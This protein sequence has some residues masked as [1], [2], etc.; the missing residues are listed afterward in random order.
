MSKDGKVHI[1]GQFALQPDCSIPLKSAVSIRYEKHDPT[2]LDVEILFLGDEMERAEAYRATRAIDINLMKLHAINKGEDSI[3]LLGLTGWRSSL[4]SM[5]LEVEAIEVGID[6]EPANRPLDVDFTVALQPS[7]ILLG[8]GSV[9]LHYKG[10]ITTTRGEDGAIMV[11]T[12]FG[13]I[14]AMEAYDYLDGT[15]F[16]DEV[17]HRVQRARLCGRVQLRVGETLRS[18]HER[19][20]EEVLSICGALS[21]CY[22]QP[23][24]AYEIEY[25][26]RGSEEDPIER[27][28]YR[29]KWHKIRERR[30][31]S[32]LI[33]SSNLRDG[34]LSNL[35]Q[36][37]KTH[38][39]SKS[40]DRGI[41]FLAHSYVSFLETAYF[42]A[43]SAMETI[44]NAVSAE[45]QGVSIGSSSWKKVQKSLRSSLAS[46]AEQ[47]FISPEAAK[48]LQEKLPELRR[49]SLVS[50]VEMAVEAYSVKTSDLW[51]TEGFAEG[52]KRA[53]EFRNGLFHAAHTSDLDLM[54]VDL[55]RI[56]TFT[57]R[58][59]L[60]AL[61]W[62][63]ERRWAWRDDSLRRIIQPSDPSAVGED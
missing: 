5:T 8:Y 57:E 58:L 39:E 28:L 45:T 49:A 14:E 54:G 51:T 10:D 50:R 34:G 62:P 12:G 40:I 36:A 1:Q 43:F 31:D 18:L 52:M 13:Q 4:T 38:P 23:V 11:E 20:Q 27:A 29:R 21:L 17:V 26:L 2:L 56:R 3:N 19:L 48:H 32:E 53:S 35:V 42:M 7:G 46:L 22:R 61:S 59:L 55:T 6:R 60:S 30:K 37:L 47:E 9:E 33:D 25:V 41:G 16:G 24:D 44:V 15:A 63:E